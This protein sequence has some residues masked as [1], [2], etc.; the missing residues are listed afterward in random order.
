MDKKPPAVDTTE[1]D[2]KPVSSPAQSL[3]PVDTDPAIHVPQD[4]R[5]ALPPV[6]T[7]DTDAGVLPP[8]K[9]TSTTQLL[10]DAVV[11]PTLDVLPRVPAAK[12]V[13]APAEPPPAAPRKPE[14]L[15][16]SSSPVSRRPPRR[17]VSGKEDQF[18]SAASAA[19]L[20]GAPEV[21]GEPARR[22]T[23]APVDVALAVA[24]AL[25]IAFAVWLFW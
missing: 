25:V 12:K 4:T 5:D 23:V 11:G 8:G 7:L 13:E 1:R 20:D 21:P 17:Q 2:L 3:V 16:A 24:A 9:A 14:R 6:S 18:E 10:D 19:S 15:E 22:V